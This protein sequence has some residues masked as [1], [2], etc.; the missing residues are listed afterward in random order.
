MNEN[1]IV[2]THNNKSLP[3]KLTMKMFRGER[4]LGFR[5]TFK[6]VCP[7]ASSVDQISVKLV[8]VKCRPGRPDKSITGPD[9]KH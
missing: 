6:W 5:M 1:G 7:R 9:T 2:N 3:A 8:S 4:I